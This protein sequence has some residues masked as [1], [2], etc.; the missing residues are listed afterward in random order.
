MEHGFYHPER[1][2]WQTNSDVPQ[3]ILD[4]YPEGTVEVPLKPGADFEWVGGA[5]VSVPLAPPTPTFEQQQAARAAAYQTEADPLFFKV[6][7]GEATEQE[8]FD[9]VAEIRTRY[10]YPE[11]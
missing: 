7:R 2:Y 4:T 1:G 6:Q 11:E 10:P 9:K 5:W 8:W 3:Y